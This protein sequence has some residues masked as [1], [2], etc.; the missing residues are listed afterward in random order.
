ME[1]QKLLVTPSPHILAKTNTRNIMVGVCIALLPTLIASAVIFG[2]YVLLLCGVTVAACVGFEA[3]YCLIMKK[4]IPVGD[5]SAVVT[6]II[7]AFNL[8]P[9]FPLWMAIIGAFISIVIV[10]QLFGGLGLN[11]A[12]PALVGR[13]V[14]QLSFTGPMIAFTYPQ[15]VA[16][17]DALASATP[18]YVLQQGTVPLMDLLLGTHGGVLGETCAITLIVGGLFMIFTK[19]ISPTIPVVY[20]GGVFVLKF[21]LGIGGGTA[22]AVAGMDALGSIL[23]GGLLLGAFFMATDYTTS[24]YTRRGKIVYGIV[25]AILTVAIREW[26]TM[27][28][29]VSYSLLL[30]NLLVPYINGLTRQRPLGVKKGKKPAADG[31]GAK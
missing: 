26:A 19:I 3:L 22:A 23:A 2:W 18:L 17:V 7:L 27:L 28:E 12:N 5:F 31:K 15:S 1:V 29:G 4:P 14:L 20:I 30:A 10:K 25:L 11:F 9:A 24:P 13:M 8:P 6:G 21:L 16:G